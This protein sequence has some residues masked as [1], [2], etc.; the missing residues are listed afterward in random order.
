M[1]AYQ[2]FLFL[3]WGGGVGGGG[4]WGWELVFESYTYLQ[5]SSKGEIHT[6]YMGCVSCRL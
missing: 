1:S 2:H 4:M 5:M 6:I 3:F